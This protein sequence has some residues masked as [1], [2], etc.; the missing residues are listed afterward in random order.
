MKSQAFAKY[1]GF[2][3]LA[4]ERNNKVKNEQAK[5]EIKL[6]LQEHHDSPRNK[7]GSHTDDG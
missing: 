4:N 1:L 5:A 7:N 2:C 3:H 6:L